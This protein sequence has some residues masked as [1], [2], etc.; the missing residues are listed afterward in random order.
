MKVLSYGFFLD[1]N[2]Y[3]SKIHNI[4]KIRWCM[5]GFAHALFYDLYMCSIKNSTSFPFILKMFI[6][7]PHPCSRFI[8][9]QNLGPFF[10]DYLGLHIRCS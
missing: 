3:F 4:L 2:N 10:Y 7:E 8:A 5:L 1:T 6:V 9:M